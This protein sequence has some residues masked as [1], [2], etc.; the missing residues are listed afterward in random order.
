MQIADGDHLAAGRYVHL[1]QVG[2]VGASHLAMMPQ[3]R[4]A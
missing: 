1:E 2:N 4:A 3:E